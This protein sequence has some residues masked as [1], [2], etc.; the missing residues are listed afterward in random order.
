[1][2]DVRAANKVKEIEDL[3]WVTR[4]GNY[5]TYFNSSRSARGVGIAIRRKISHK[6]LQIRRDEAEENYILLDVEIKGKKLT[7]GCVYGP[8][9]NN[10][11]FYR[12][13]K[14]DVNEMVNP[15][16]IGG[17][18]NTILDQDGTEN[19]LDRIGI[20]RVPNRTNSNFINDWIREGKIIEPFRAL[21]PEEREISYLSYRGVRDDIG[22]GRA[23]NG[24]EYYGKTRLDFFLVDNVLL[25]YVKSV[26]YEDRLSADFDHKEVLLTI[27]KTPPVGKVTIYDNTLSDS[28]S[29]SIGLLALFDSYANHVV[30]RD[31]EFDRNLTQ[32]DILI[33]NAELIK[34]LLLLERGDIREL[35]ERL[36][37]TMESIG[38][39]INRLRGFNMLEREYQ[40]DYRALHEVSMMGIKNKLMEVQA[41]V[42]RDK[43]RAREN[44]VN[45]VGYM[46]GKFGAFS[47]QA[48]D[49]RRE[50]LRFD[51]LDLKNRAGKFRDF[52]IE[53]NETATGAFCR[54]NKEGGVNDDIEQIKGPDGQDFVSN[55][56]RGKHIG[57][58]YS[59]LYKKKL[60]NL[61]SI[62]D[63]LHG[64][65]QD[66]GWVEGRKLT[67]E[68]RDSLEGEVTLVELERALE[69]SNLKSTSG[70]DGLSFK[71]LQKF[72]G[73]VKGLTLKMVN[74]TFR[75]GELTETFKMGLIKLIP[76]KGNLSKVGDWRPITLLC[77]GYKLVSGIVA[78]RLEK[79]LM[80][81]IGWAQKGFL[82]SKNINTCMMNI[83][84]SING[85][86]GSNE[87]TGILCVDF[88][89]D[90]DSIEHE[91]I[92]TILKFFNFGNGMV[93]MVMTL[94]RG[95]R[96]RVIMGDGYSTDIKIR[97]GTPQG[98]RA[99][100]F[101]F[102]IAIEILLMKIGLLDGDGID[103]CRNIVRRV[104]ALDLEKLTA[105]A[106]ADDLT[107]IF[108][109]SERSVG[110]VIEV[111]GNFHRMSGLG[112]NKGK[113]Q[114]L[115]AGSDDW[116][117]G[118]NIHGI[119]V[120]D[121]VCV[122]GVEIDGK[123]TR[124][125]ENWDKVLEKM[126]R[127]CIFWGNFGL[128]ISGR[129]MAAKTYVLLQ[130]VYLMGILPLPSEYGDRMNDLIVEFV[131]G[132]DRPIERRRQLLC[133]ELGG[134]GI[135]DMNIMNVSMKCAWI[136][137][138]KK[139]KTQNVKDY[140]MCIIMGE[141]EM[142]ADCLD[143]REVEGTGLLLLIDIMD[144]WQRFKVEYYKMGRNREEM[145][146][147]ENRMLEGMEDTL[148]MRIFG[149]N[150][151]AGLRDRMRNV[152]YKDLH[153]EDGTLLDMNTI[154][155]KLGVN[156]N[157]AEYFRM[158]AELEQ[159]EET[160]GERIDE[161]DGRSLDDAVVS[162]A[163]GCKKFRMALVGRRSSLYKQND[164]REIASGRTLLGN[165]IE[166]MSRVRIELNF[167]LWKISFLESRFKEFVFRLLQGKLYVNQILDNFAEVRPQ[168]TFCVILEKRRMKRE[169]IEEEGAE[170]LG[171][172]NRQ[173]HESVI[174]LFWECTAVRHLIDSVGNW[175]ANT[176]GRRF[177]KEKF[178]SGIDDISPQNI[179]MCVVIVHYIKFILYECKLRHQLPTLTHVRYELEGLGKLFSKR[180]DWREQVEDI[181]EL[182]Y[183]M[184][185][186]DLG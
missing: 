51:D 86:W 33:R 29:E 168:C 115:V 164:P 70:W 146:L 177:N 171:R 9:E 3:F 94:L 182:V 1:M 172:I 43:E 180:E 20:G 54:L 37:N 141:E 132:S 104:E 136:K 95:R 150:R 45:R 97:R 100:P 23:R 58:F 53:N 156:I 18:F 36:N 91:A 74:E 151:Y 145:I 26:R 147:F 75:E 174:H 38:V 98:D 60:D 103:C 160:L 129:V 117:V 185:D 48:E 128:S 30:D 25:E 90:F 89:K 68:E 15:V 175:L 179:R 154:N 77:C 82:K 5:V 123:L 152:R 107:I 44:L 11:N 84:N 133:E 144:C 72:W 99:S 118:I 155:R 110:I 158:R 122:L 112:L 134:Y 114:L 140:P 63:F 76:K 165:G 87:P 137:R 40:C 167:G 143:R 80:K 111:M 32:L 17:D 181:P 22:G 106:Y 119:T 34:I 178:F 42:K 59:E 130:A 142:V 31:V 153:N 131:K 52:L 159:I 47:V 50:L 139:E 16:I 57:D 108:Q 148:E 13:L 169:N 10:V 83:I 69:T 65:G 61:F 28:L 85:A 41:R 135:I 96:A 73:D 39:V 163:K 161:E 93:G 176:N 71:V 109:M 102:I 19:N 170:W 62:E 24:V 184:M 183:R 116:P 105:E 157:W 4:N 27:G 173:C 14:R 21:Y 186:D 66:E 2:S 121:K 12:K 7:L 127:Y 166:E 125:N 92:S 46:A 49:C 35:K 78:L 101:I 81:M 67:E 8:N 88:S 64:G 162:K 6:I 113:T 138:W 124:L 149:R 120:V 55:E 56:E 79:Y 126:R